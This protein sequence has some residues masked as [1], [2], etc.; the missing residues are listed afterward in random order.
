MVVNYLNHRCVET[1]SAYVTICLINVSDGVC[2]KLLN[3][4]N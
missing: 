2:N 1:L 3:L 4:K